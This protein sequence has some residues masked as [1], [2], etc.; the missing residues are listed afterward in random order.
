MN[1]PAGRENTFYLPDFCT[2]RATLAVVLIVELTALVLTLARQ[3]VIVDFWTD[4]VRTSLFLL[5]IGL[6]GSAL[7]C[8]LR[9]RLKRLSVAAGSAAVLGLMSAVVAGISLC[10]YLIGRTQMVSNSGGLGLFP[11]EWE[12]VQSILWR[13]SENEVEG[14]TFRL[15]DIYYRENM[16]KSDQLQYLR[17]KERK[18]GRG[19]IDLWRA[20]QKN[21]L[22]KLEQS[23][24]P[25]EEMLMHK[26]FLLGRQ[27][28]FVDFDLFGML[29]N[30]LYTGRYKLPDGHPRLKEW[31]RR[32]AKIKSVRLK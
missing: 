4:L 15:N 7:L 3:S 6:A 1:T 31:Y 30:F 25:F 22:K 2:S 13:Y 24:V 5:W 14:A 29:G 20:E 11:A 10:V 28:R 12:G 8:L 9:A 23:L 26:D 19:C 17:F 16:P 21:W 18:F 27:P 32:M